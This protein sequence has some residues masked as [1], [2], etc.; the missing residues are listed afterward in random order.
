MFDGNTPDLKPSSDS[1]KH[2]VLFIATYGVNRD[3]AYCNC[4]EQSH[5]V[6]P[7]ALFLIL[8]RISI[9]WDV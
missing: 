4:Q 3:L 1:V 9:E 6:R 5:M 7:R 2:I 8:I